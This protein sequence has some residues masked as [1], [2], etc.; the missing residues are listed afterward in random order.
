MR[1]RASA[2]ID[3][4]YERR[5]HAA[6]W[7]LG[8]RHLVLAGRLQLAVCQT[9]REIRSVVSPSRTELHGTR[10]TPGRRFHGDGAADVERNRRAAG[11]SDGDVS[12][13][14]ARA[15]ACRHEP[16]TERSSASLLRGK[17]KSR[18]VTACSMRYTVKVVAGNSSL[19][20]SGCLTS[21]WKHFSSANSPGNSKPNSAE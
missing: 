14:G 18:I 16:S 7:A 13:Y 8:R 12:C 5:R 9:R 11:V 10:S 6:Y 4:D 2:A 21:K 19:S 20:Y 17:P 1:C 15:V 3:R